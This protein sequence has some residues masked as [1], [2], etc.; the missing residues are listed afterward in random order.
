MGADSH[1]G[2]DLVFP[3]E[4][5]HEPGVGLAPV[6]RYLAVGE[7]RLREVASPG[8]AQVEGGA[9]QGGRQPQTGI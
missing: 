5:D 7:G 2:L 8:P 1:R 6:P 9:G 4:A 3:A